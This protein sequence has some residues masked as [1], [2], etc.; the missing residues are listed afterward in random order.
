MPAAARSHWFALN[1]VPEVIV[2][3]G[4]SKICWVTPR[5]LAIRSTR[6]TSKPTV[7]SPSLNWK[8]L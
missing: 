5:S 4:V 1:D 6:S 7:L 8:G 2:S 3:N